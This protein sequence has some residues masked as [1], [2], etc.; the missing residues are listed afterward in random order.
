MFL[1]HPLPC[2]WVFPT[3]EVPRNS[4]TPRWQSMSINQD[5]DPHP[6]PSPPE[7]CLPPSFIRVSESRR[8][9]SLRRGREILYRLSL[10]NQNGHSVFCMIFDTPCTPQSTPTSFRFSFL[11]VWDHP[12]TKRGKDRCFRF[13]FQRAIGT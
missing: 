3:Q 4:D 9:R 1:R 6:P 11:H 12:K 7:P 13:R 8:G 5:P 2:R 10:R